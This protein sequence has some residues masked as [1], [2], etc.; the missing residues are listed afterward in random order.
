MREILVTRRVRGRWLKMRKSPARCGR[1]GRSVSSVVTFTS[2][3]SCRLL[4]KIL[5]SLL[6]QSCRVC[7]IQYV[8]KLVLFSLSDLKNKKLIKKQTYMKTETCKLY[9]RDFWIFL[10]NTIKIDPYHF[11]LYRFKVGPF[12]ETQCMSHRR[13]HLLFTEARWKPG[14]AEFGSQVAAGLS[15]FLQISGD[16]QSKSVIGV[17][18][19]VCRNI[20]ILARTAALLTH[21][22]VHIDTIIHLA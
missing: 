21:V 18:C 10:P 19:V 16:V 13:Q 22:S 6:R 2:L 8:S 7:L 3:H 20:V 12:I 17:C 5:S 15:P 11:E 4:I 1:L 14:V 9:A